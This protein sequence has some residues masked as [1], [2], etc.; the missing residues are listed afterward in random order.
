MKAKEF[1]QKE[2]LFPK[3]EI[4]IDYSELLNLLNS[5]ADSKLHESAEGIERLKILTSNNVYKLG[6]TDAKLEA[7]DFILSLT[8]SK[9]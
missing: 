9:K 8:N 6:F 2:G 3:G 1:L 4:T 7:R 5:F